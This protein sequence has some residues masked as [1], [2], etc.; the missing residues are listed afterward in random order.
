MF[1][2]LGGVYEEFVFAPRL[3][4]QHSCFCAIQ[5]K[6]LIDFIDPI[7]IPVANHGAVLCSSRI[8]VLFTFIDLSRHA[9][10]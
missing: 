8:F 7:N 9:V 5:V 1:Q 2:T 4:N 6:F 3:D 10:V